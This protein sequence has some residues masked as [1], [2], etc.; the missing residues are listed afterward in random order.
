M[1]KETILLIFFLILSSVILSGCVSVPDLAG[2]GPVGKEVAGVSINLI[3][4]EPSW[5]F[6]RGCFWTI[7][8]QVYNYGD[9]EARNVNVQMELGDAGTGAVRDTLQVYVG[10]L[11]PGE[12]KM[13]LADLDGECI[14]EYTLNAYPVLL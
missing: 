6:S 13:I 5:S 11:A 9:I 10:S 12:S 4:S 2:S 8:L 1:R 3:K 7:T 14:N